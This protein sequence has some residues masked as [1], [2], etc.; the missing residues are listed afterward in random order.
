MIYKHKVIIV[1]LF[2]IFTAS[3]SFCEEIEVNIKGVDD[4]VKSTKQLI[5]RKQF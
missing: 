5:I 3:I 1:I 2:I 4:G